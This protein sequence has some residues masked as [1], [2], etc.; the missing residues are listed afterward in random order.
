M[1]RLVETGFFRI[2]A[3]SALLK[4][5]LISTEFLDK[6]EEN[7][8]NEFGYVKLK[9][10]SHKKWIEGLAEKLDIA[11]KNHLLS[12]NKIRQMRERFDLT[13]A[14]EVS[15]EMNQSL[16]LESREGLESS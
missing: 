4:D 1:L 11:E 15:P 10:P 16:S 6:L 14:A 9:N 13:T 3:I 8:I 7:F 5:D 12:E 2:E